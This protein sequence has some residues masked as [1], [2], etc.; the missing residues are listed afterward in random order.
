MNEENLF[1]IVGIGDVVVDAFIKLE[2]GHTEETANGAEY[3]LPFGS[4]IPYESMTEVPAV[5]NSANAVVSASRLGLKTALVS[6]VGNDNDGKKCVEK[7]KKENVST[8]FIKVEENKKTNYHYVLW[9]GDDRTILIKHENFHPELDD[10]KTKWIYLSSIGENEKYLHDDVLK[11]LEK[12][13]ETKLAFQPGTYQL[14]LGKELLP[15]YKKATV[16]CMNKEEAKELLETN[17]DDIKELLEGVASMGPQTVLITDGANGSY[18][19]YDGTLLFM[20]TYPDIKT[21]YERTGA[22]DA[23]FSTFVSYMAKGFDEK[24]AIQRAPINAMNVVQCIGAQEGLLSEEKIEEYL[25]NAPEDY[26]LEI[27]V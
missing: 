12:Y 26:K 5:G 21:P 22:G 23:F 20:P 2:V 3:C 7:L 10:A 4:K 15:I 24:H 1:D 16:V 17:S 18:V 11:Y 27:L 14:I 13:P 25:K 19:K 9:F 6:C 8:N